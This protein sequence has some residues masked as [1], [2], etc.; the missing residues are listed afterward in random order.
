MRGRTVRSPGPGAAR[1]LMFRATSASHDLFPRSGRAT[2]PTGPGRRL[3]EGAARGLPPA[4]TLPPENRLDPLPRPFVTLRHGGK[5]R[6]C[7]GNYRS[8]QASPVGLLLEQA[9]PAAAVK[10]PRFPPSVR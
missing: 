1:S 7:I 8:D 4:S 2:R 10:D 3:V 5:L 9:A 6:G